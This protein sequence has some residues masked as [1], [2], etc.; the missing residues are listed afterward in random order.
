[1]MAWGL[2]VFN[3]D[4]WHLAGPTELCRALEMLKTERD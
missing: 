4:T 3:L 2:A 1:M